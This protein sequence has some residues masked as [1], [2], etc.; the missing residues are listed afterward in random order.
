MREIIIDTDNGYQFSSRRNYPIV[1]YEY[2]GNGKVEKLHE[3]YIDS[4]V[5][6]LSKE[7][8]LGIVWIDNNE[9]VANQLVKYLYEKGI[10]VSRNLSAYNYIK[11]SRFVKRFISYWIETKPEKYVRW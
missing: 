10:G 4:S 8:N 9:M 6:F 5:D 2:F 7:P 11:E 3:G 1:I